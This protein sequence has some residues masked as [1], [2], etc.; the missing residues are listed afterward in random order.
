[1]G[2][3]GGGGGGGGTGKGGGSPKRSRLGDE[4][5]KRRALVSTKGKAQKTE[6]GRTHERGV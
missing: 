3:G 1:V 2:G 5:K 4:G 6:G